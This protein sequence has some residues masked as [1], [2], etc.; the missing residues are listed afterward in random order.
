MSQITLNWYWHW[1]DQT[2]IAK[3]I[4][5]S[6]PEWRSCAHTWRWELQEWRGWS[7]QPWC[8]WWVCC[9]WT[10]CEELS[11]QS[12]LDFSLPSSARRRPTIKSKTSAKPLGED[13]SCHK[14]DLT[15]RLGFQE[16]TWR[17]SN[18]SAADWTKKVP[19]LRS[20]LSSH[21]GFGLSQEVGEQ[22]GVVESPIPGQ[23]C[24]HG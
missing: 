17:S 23:Y 10:P 5:G 19:N 6:P 9:Q 8:C 18:I 2:S 12:Q 1:V 21:Q 14:L 3:L 7:G 20:I 13:V 4:V 24:R 11:S 16:P 22:Y 15:S